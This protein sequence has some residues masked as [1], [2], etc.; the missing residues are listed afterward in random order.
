AKC[1]V[2]VAGRGVLAAGCA[3][4]VRGLAERTGAAL[5]TTLPAKGLFDGHAQDLGLAGKFAHPAAERV[6]AAA[7]LLVG[8]GAT[9]T[10]A[11]VVRVVDEAV[12]GPGETVLG[13]P[14]E[15]LARLRGPAA[16][17]TPWFEPVGPAA[18][19]WLEDLAGYAPPIPAGTVDP[20]VALAAIDRLIPAGAV[21]VVGGGRWSAFACALITRPRAGR[22]VATGGPAG[23][24]FATAAGVALASPGRKVVVFDGEH[25][26]AAELAADVDLTLF[27]MKEG[28]TSA[29]VTAEAA[30]RPGFAVAEVC[31]APSVLPR[32][33]RPAP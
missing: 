1:P 13:N 6:L 19:C 26:G 7:D 31:V 25:E 22:F 16:R 23:R 20:R 8:L 17:K 30:L 12:A 18:D 4:L 2:L 11:R 15:V 27:L 33:L 21:V 9:V 24:A 3:D 10:G 32:H 14:A 5:A 28:G 29:A